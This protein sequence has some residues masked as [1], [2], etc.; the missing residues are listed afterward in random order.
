M[1]TRVNARDEDY[2]DVDIDD[3]DPLDGLN[4]AAKRR[5]MALKELQARLMVL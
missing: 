3:Y 5:V 2:G 4:V 1:A